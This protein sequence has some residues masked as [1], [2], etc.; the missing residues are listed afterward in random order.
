MRRIF[1]PGSWFQGCGFVALYEAISRL[2]S[3]FKIKGMFELFFVGVFFVNLVNRF[4]GTIDM[5][6]PDRSGRFSGTTS[7]ALGPRWLPFGRS[8]RH[9]QR[10]VMPQCSVELH[11]FLSPARK[12]PDMTNFLRAALLAAG[13]FVAPVAIAQQTSQNP[14]SQTGGDALRNTTPPN[15]AGDAR[16]GDATAAPGAAG[17]AALRQTTKPEGQKQLGGVNGNGASAAAGSSNSR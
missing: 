4:K 2:P 11:A 15:R 3:G 7:P 8:G 10:R 13:V 1:G 6:A 14:G 9:L 17:G 12:E 16:A 5:V